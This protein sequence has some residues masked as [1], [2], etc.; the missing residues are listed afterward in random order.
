M[1]FIFTERPLGFVIS[2]K[3]GDEVE[4]KAKIEKDST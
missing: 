1:A 3:K 2:M 4:F